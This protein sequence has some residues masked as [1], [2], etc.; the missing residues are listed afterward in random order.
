MDVAQ[1]VQSLDRRTLTPLIRQALRRDDA[2]L[3]RWEY[4]AIPSLLG[5]AALSTVYRLS[6]TARVGGEAQPW[7]LILKAL[8]RPIAP[9]AGWDREVP[10]FRSGLLDDLPAGLAA[11]RCFAIEERPEAIWF[12]QE[13]VAEEG[14]ARWP[15]A[16]FAL[17]ARHLGRFSG[18]SLVAGPLPDAPW[19]SRA[20]LQ[21]RVDGNAAFWA[22]QLPVRDQT[23]LDRLF[24]ADLLDR[25][26]QVWEERHELLA[27]LACLP[28]TLV[29]GDADRRNLFARRGPD[30]AEETVAIDWAWLGVAALGADLVNLVAASALW[31]QADTD[32]LPALAE[33]CVPAYGAG[34]ADAGWSGD[35][36]LP[37]VGFA[38]ATALRYGP[39]GPF[40]MILQHPERARASGYV[41]ADR[42][43]LVQRFAFDQLD[44]VRGDIAAL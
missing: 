35:A 41:L 21:G 12:W 1:Q 16:R 4:R 19:L 5:A 18:P 28:Q 37:R 20:T 30:G 3:V 34:L 24:P 31:F 13:D 39:C 14:N 27:L 38:V 43:A 40:A 15:V 29:H 42:M 10:A 6:G 33:A 36:R 2:E 7:S 9:V 22:G 17:A 44:A 11:P 25:S 26:R 23:L 32:D 8:T